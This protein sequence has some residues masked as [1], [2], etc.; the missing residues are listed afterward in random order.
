[1]LHKRT[2]H[3]LRNIHRQLRTLRDD[4]RVTE[5][6]LIPVTDDADDWR[7][8]A[9]VSETPIAERKYRK[10]AAHAERLRHHRDELI[11]RI[12]RLEADQDALLDQLSSRSSG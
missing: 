2:E 11:R 1:M 3:R 4:L 12:Q 10:A 7:L 8:R 5:E 9:L 6:Q